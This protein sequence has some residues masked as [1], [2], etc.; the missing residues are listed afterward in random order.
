MWLCIF[1]I[2][3]YFLKDFGFCVLV[4]FWDF[5]DDLCCVEGIFRWFDWLCK[6]CSS[7][8][9]GESIYKYIE[10]IVFFYYIRIFYFI[11]LVLVSDF[12]VVSFFFLVYRDKM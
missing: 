4:G 3:I 9:I 11:R 6:V 8:G 10:K 5:F 2:G 12:G 7:N 1:W